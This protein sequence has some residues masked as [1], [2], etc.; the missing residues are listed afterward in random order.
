VRFVNAARSQLGNQFF[1]KKLII[2]SVFVS[3]CQL[4]SAQTP[5][6]TATYD[7]ATDVSA[8]NV[9]YSIAIGDFNGDGKQVLLQLRI[10]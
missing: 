5:N 7:A 9:P 10:H 1:M 3:L 2:L 6:C 4:V 8:G